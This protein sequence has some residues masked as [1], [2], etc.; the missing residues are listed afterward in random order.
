MEGKME[1]KPEI[2]NKNAYEKPILIKL[3]DLRGIVLGPSFGSGESGNAT[4][5]R[6]ADDW[7]S[8]FEEDDSS[9]NKGIISNSDPYAPSDPGQP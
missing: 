9:I 4:I 1:K 5:Y 2:L 8:S 3:G 6:G 7:G